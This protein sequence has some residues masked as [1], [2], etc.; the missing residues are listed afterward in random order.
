[1]YYNDCFLLLWLSIAVE[2]V[3]VKQ[4][5]FL[6]IPVLA[7]CHYSITRAIVLWKSLC[8][9]ASTANFKD[10]QMHYVFDWSVHLSVC[11]CPSPTCRTTFP[12]QHLRPSGVLSC[13]PDGLELTP[14]FY[15]GSNAQHR[16]F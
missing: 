14:G 11:A 8:F 12:A 4:I 3:N 10:P 6:L 7:V 2:T 1:M 16:L 13:W 5:L 9:Y 15:P